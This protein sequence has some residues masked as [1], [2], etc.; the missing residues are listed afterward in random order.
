MGV[1]YLLLFQCSFVDKVIYKCKF[2]SWAWVFD[3]SYRTSQ[4]NDYTKTMYWIITT[5]TSTG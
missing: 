3:L 1:P 5:M 4:S 2:A